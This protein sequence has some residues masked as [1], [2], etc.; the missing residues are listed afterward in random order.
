MTTWLANHFASALEHVV[1]EI[2]LP[3]SQFL[4]GEM[5]PPIT[6]T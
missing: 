4:V 6:L 1:A 5:G 3:T 2:E